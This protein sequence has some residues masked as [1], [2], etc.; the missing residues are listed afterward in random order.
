MGM[1]MTDRTAR[2]L[3][4]T[5]LDNTLYDWFGYF[6]PSFYAMVACGAEILGMREE[7]L[8][9]E[10]RVVHQRHHDVEHPFA[11]LE[12]AAAEKLIR[13]TSFRKAA[14]RLDPA[15]HAFNRSRCQLLRAYP[16]VLGTLR[17][18]QGRGVC[19]V[20]Y[21]E[22]K[23][24]AVMGRLQRLQLLR[25]FDRIYCRE[26]S[27]TRHPNPE[28]AQKLSANY[29]VERLV[30]LRLD[31]RKPAPEVL[32][33]ICD[34]E[35][36]SPEESVYVGD[37]LAKDIMMANRAGIYAVWARYGEAHQRENYEK[38]VAISHWTDEDVARER[39]LAREATE[40]RPDFTLSRGF[41]EIRR[42][43]I[44]SP[45]ER[46][47]EALVELWERAFDLNGEASAIGGRR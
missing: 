16:G 33:A 9:E 22:S 32:L 12:T 27:L 10:I 25:L 17:L 8:L 18:L 35:G 1:P 11:L 20:A 14:A 28:R 40:A 39:Y 46:G 45:L 21:S 2:R 42:I 4:I 23:K 43:F 36:I 15:F 19:L 37:S 29:P 30:E 24:H 13:K 34:R 3:L 31:A 6:I 26:S 38:L 44:S 5:D 7:D 47:V 41:R